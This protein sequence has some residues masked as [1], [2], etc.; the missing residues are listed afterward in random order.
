MVRT[1]YKTFSVHS[2]GTYQETNRILLIKLL[3]TQAHFFLSLQQL[4]SPV[5]VSYAN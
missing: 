3:N 5:I 2:S 4:S 1:Y